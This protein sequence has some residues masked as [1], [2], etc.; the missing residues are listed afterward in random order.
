MRLNFELNVLV[1]APK[2]ARELERMLAED[3]AAS[4]E[5]L[6]LDF[7]HR[8]LRQRLLEAALRPLAPLL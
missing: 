7:L 1:A 2:A 4:R 6:L 3:F 5:I 8:P